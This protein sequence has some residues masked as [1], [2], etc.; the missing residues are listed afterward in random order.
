VGNT[1]S[2]VLPAM[3]APMLWRLIAALLGWIR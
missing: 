2:G 3:I 1:L